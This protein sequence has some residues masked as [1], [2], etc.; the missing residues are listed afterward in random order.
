MTPERWQQVE[1]IY[2]EAAARPPAD[3]I[4][5]LDRQCAGDAALRAEVERMLAAD[6]EAGSFL[7]AA[8]VESG[9]LSDSP[10]NRSLPG[11][12]RWTR[13]PISSRSARCCSR[14]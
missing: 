7:E 9:C 11:G 2:Q 13:G 12:S 10:A 8:G 6:A 3:R 5:F 1:R 4:A 14:C